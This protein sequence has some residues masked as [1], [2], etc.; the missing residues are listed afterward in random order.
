M[1]TFLSANLQK[2]KSF[3]EFVLMILYPYLNW[4]CF[5]QSHSKTQ[6]SF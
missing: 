5:I 4:K 1:K 2:A 6:G 3:E